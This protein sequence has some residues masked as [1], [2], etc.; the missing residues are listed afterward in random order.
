ME[1]SPKEINLV[2]LALLCGIGI[3][4]FLLGAAV[5]QTIIA[6]NMEKQGLE[7]CFA[8]PELMLNAPF[9]FAPLPNSSF[10]KT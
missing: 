2:I 7:L 6:K 3:C 1:K 5:N 8:N 4:L 9:V 10:D